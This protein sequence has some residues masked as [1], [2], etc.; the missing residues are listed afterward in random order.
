MNRVLLLVLAALSILAGCNAPAN[1]Y[2]LAVLDRN[3]YD[4]RDTI[5]F[6]IKVDRTDDPYNI[7][8]ATRTEK[9]FFSPTI[10]TELTFTAPSGEKWRGKT[11][12]PVDKI[13][14]A[15][16]D[17]HSA[18]YGYIDT[19]W[20]WTEGVKFDEKGEWEI[21][22]MITNRESPDNYIVKGIHEIGINCK[23][24]ERKR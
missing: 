9:D 22:L 13:L 11:E 8:F 2:D 24:N 14:I 21:S 7:Y 1:D 19:E 10:N 12:I 6:K 23:K 4:T 17:S 3:G 5:H 20:L 16:G 18:L 15:E